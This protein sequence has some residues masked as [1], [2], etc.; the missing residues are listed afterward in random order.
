MTIEGYDG[1]RVLLSYDVSGAA[2]A[3]AARV[4]QIIF[5][6]WRISEG[7][8]RVH[9]QEKGFIH[10]LGVVWV[11]QSVLVMPPSDAS[12]LS[13]RLRQLGVRVATGPA[14][15]PRSTL[16]AFRRGSQSPA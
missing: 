8:A 10:R 13:D 16:E 4:C 9:Y 6:R 11:G 12:E 15:I 3:V 14:S 5:G 2:R 1:E 7:P